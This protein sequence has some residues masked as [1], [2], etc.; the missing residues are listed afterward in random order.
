MPFVALLLKKI[1]A[2]DKNQELDNPI[3]YENV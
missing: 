3:V 2:P 1:K